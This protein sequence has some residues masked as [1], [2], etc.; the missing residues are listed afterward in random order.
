MVISG[1]RISL[2]IKMH[3]F[4]ES[5]IHGLEFTLVICYSEREVNADFGANRV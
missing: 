5:Y 3:G 4:L 1:C 2:K